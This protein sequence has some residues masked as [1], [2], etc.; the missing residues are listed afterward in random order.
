MAH[1][2]SGTLGS[3]SPLLYY[4]LY[5]DQIAAS[6]NS[7]TVRIT[8]KF[9]VN[10]S[11]A[12]WYGYPCNWRARVHNSYGSW[13]SIKGSES[14]NG[15][16][17]LR[18]YT[19][20]LTV[21]VGTSS[22]VSITVG[23][24]T[25]HSS[26]SSWN[27]STTGSFT[28]GSTNTAPYFPSGA[29]ITI[30]EGGSAS[31]KVLSG[32]IPEN[33]NTVYIDW[34]AAKDNEGGTLYYSLN[35]N[36]NNGGYSQIDWGTDLAHS[37]NIGSGNEGQTLQYYVDARDNGNLWSNKIYS[38][39]LTKNR[40]TG[41]TLNST[42][43]VL[44]ETNAITFTQSGAANTNG[45]TTFTYK[46]SSADIKVY[47]QSVS[48]SSF[49]VAIHKS[50]TVPSGAYILF[51]DLKNKFK[52]SNFAGNL[53]FKLTT[54]NAY[55]TSKASEK[56]VAVDLRTAPNAVTSCSIDTNAANSTCIKTTAD[57]KNSY[58]IPDGENVIRV[59]WSGGSCKL[60]STITY[61]VQAKIGSGSYTNV[62]TG[63]ASSVNYFNY[64]C[65]KQTRQQNIIFKIIVKASFGNE[66]TSAKDTAA[67]ALHYYNEP[68]ISIGNITR[69]ETTATIAITVKT[70][71]S[72]PNV[73][74]RGSW[75]NRLTG[76]SSNLQTGN[77][78]QAQTS[79]NISLTGLASQ[80]TYTL[81]VT[82]NDGTGFAS[83]K[84]QNISIG[85]NLPI[86][87][88]NKYGLGVGGET[89]NASY[90]LRVRGSIGLTDANGLCSNG[91]IFTYAGDANGMGMAIQSGGTMVVGSGES[92]VNLMGTISNKTDETLHLASDNGINFV[93][94]CQT[95]GSR[96]TATLNSSGTFNAPNVQVAGNNVYHTGRKPSKSDVGLSNVNNWG[97]SSDVGANSTS[98]YA[99]TNMVA[100]VRG[101]K[102]SY[103]YTGSS[104]HPRLIPAKGDWLRVGSTS[105][106]LLPYS[107]NNSSLGTS[108]WRFGNIWSNHLNGRKCNG[109]NAGSWFSSIVGVGADGVAEVGRYLD[110]HYTNEESKDWH[111]RMEVYNWD[112]IS[113]SGAIRLNGS[114]YPGG[115]LQPGWDVGQGGARFY[116]VYCNNVNQSSDKNLKENIV[117]VDDNTSSFSK[118]KSKT[119]FKDFLVEDLKIATYR[120]KRE[121]KLSEEELE[122]N[123]KGTDLEYREEDNQIGF[124]AQDVINTDIGST[125][126]YGEEGS[127]NYSP[128]G[129]TT[130]VAKALQEEIKDR[131]NQISNL[132]NRINKLEEV[133]KELQK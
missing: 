7:R 95:I 53:T 58:F 121:N 102:I 116:T 33:I 84:S 105:G 93:T 25:N 56:V 26:Y 29:V 115:N 124:I 32:I 3:G 19:Q 47:N 98:Q 17:N 99:T 76:S 97:A 101:E 94:N 108:T 8:A 9:K 66:Y 62:A 78:T 130:V 92:P 35:A 80:S 114:I 11:S 49:N 118:M 44:Y 46:I 63:L 87:D 88:I 81:T 43:K 55:G 13:A 117:Y 111:S 72:I 128:S 5:A 75:Y 12:S 69:T 40:F 45:N 123:P 68:V 132:E 30:R 23:L 119:P 48:G 70:T 20:D 125:F 10:G 4:E 41:A 18:T 21:D 107:N 73:N 106:G 86:V 91:G 15:G 127:M 67:V 57:T 42:T 50:G 126:V 133:I 34:T 79:Q 90:S 85:A 37:Y 74:T 103:D 100:K 59:N 96:V 83:N 71:T 112:C 110:W 31:G 122:R 38:S 28:V 64:I 22:S 104:D 65:P 89:A 52:N 77:L 1:I 27:G 16:N 36:V 129:F 6:G 60:G 61:D 109:G 51:E 82:Y 2:K 113:F 54:T 39:V 131:D 24:E 120:Y 14:W